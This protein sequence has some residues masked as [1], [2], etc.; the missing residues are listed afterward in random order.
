M[1]HSNE[2]ATYELGVLVGQINHSLDIQFLN[3]ATLGGAAKNT[4]P[5]NVTAHA[6]AAAKGFGLSGG[7]QA[8]AIICHDELCLRI[9]QGMSLCDATEEARR[10]EPAKSAFDTLC[11]KVLTKMVE[12]QQ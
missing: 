6:L 9:S 3:L 1:E 4:S 2:K 11:D 5:E 8:L 12:A 10:T 7:D